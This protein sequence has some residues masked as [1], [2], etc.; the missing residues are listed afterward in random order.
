MDQDPRRHIY[1]YFASQDCFVRILVS[2]PAQQGS[3]EEYQLLPGSPLRAADYRRGVVSRFV[4]FEDAEAEASEDNLGEL[5]E[6]V[7]DV[8]PHLALG[9]VRLAEGPAQGGNAKQ[10]RKPS[11]RSSPQASG[12]RRLRRLAREA[13]ERLGRS[14]FGQPEA[15]EAMGG[16]LRRAAA[17]FRERG[18]LASAL[19]VGPTGVG[20][21]ELARALARELGGESQLLRIDCS[22]YAEGHEYAKLLGAPPGY[23]GHDAGGQLARAWSAGA[24]RV[25]L[26]DEFEKAHPKLH[27]LL[28]Q[29]LDEGLLSTSCGRQL[30]FGESILLMTSNTGSSELGAASDSIG[31]DPAPPSQA[32]RQEILRSALDQCFRPEL[33][34]RL[35]ETL[36]FNSLGPEEA[37]HIAQA[38]L[39]RLATKVRQAGLRVRFSRAVARWV[40]E[41]GLEAGEGAR[42]VLRALGRHVEG[43]LAGEVLDGMRGGWISVSVKR[44]RLNFKRD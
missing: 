39:T 23:V 38:H 41:R 4:E 1:K 7:V 33:L 12:K 13:P 27:N 5:F 26:F 11:A 36:L 44:A 14:V 15:L 10:Q 32:A 16:V 35:D 8:N 22:E 37:L 17:G 9:T 24:P 31:F 3:A 18:P 40:A 43:P 19:M 25:V 6:L 30:D 29:V 42:G 20:K 2:G 28:L 21:T 34:A